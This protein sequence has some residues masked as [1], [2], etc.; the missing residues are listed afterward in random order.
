M[1][2]NA[3]TS[4]PAFVTGQVLTAQQQTEINTGIPVFATSV[5]RDAAFGGTGEKTLAEG[6][7]AFLE[8]SNT[9]QFYDGALWQ[10]VGTSPGI[11]RVGGASFSAVSSVAFANDTFTSTYNVYWVVMN[12]TATST[13]QNLSLRVR[14]NGGSKTGANYVGQAYYIRA[15]NATLTSNN[16][17]SATSQVLGRA[18]TLLA[19]NAIQV[20]LYVANPASASSSTSWWGQGTLKDTGDEAAAN[21]I[22]GTYSTAEA[23]TGLE[24]FVTGTI[25][26]NYNVY[27][28]VES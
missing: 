23:H 1:G 12:I 10:S 5:E 6:Q 17:S 2:A 7:F 21:T 20:S 28:L 24:F 19:N 18:Y 16:T 13:G 14:D 26:G 25:T 4:V 15:S 8:D 9:T 11:V 3:Q 27:A 22:M